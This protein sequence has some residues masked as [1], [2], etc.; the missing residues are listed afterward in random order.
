MA[1]AAVGGEHHE[2]HLILS[3]KTVDLIGGVA[4]R[5]VRMNGHVCGLSLPQELSNPTPPAVLRERPGTEGKAVG[6]GEGNVGDRFD[7]VQHVDR[8]VVQARQGHGVFEGT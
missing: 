3:H 5:E 8:R 1:T 2:V 6:G 7:H 4:V